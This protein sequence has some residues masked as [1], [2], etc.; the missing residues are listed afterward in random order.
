MDATPRQKK[1]NG[2]KE[3]DPMIKITTKSVRAKGIAVKRGCSRKKASK[4]INSMLA[5]KSSPRPLTYPKP[6][7]R[8]SITP[9][10]IQAGVIVI[11]AIW[12]ARSVSAIGA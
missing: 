1:A 10:R 5:E 11:S 7:R 2:T 3:I 9:P 6:L 8:H 4:A 12:S